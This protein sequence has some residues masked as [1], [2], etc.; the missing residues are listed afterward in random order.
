MCILPALLSIIIF[1]IGPKSLVNVLIAIFLMILAL[2]LFIPGLIF[3]IVGIK[4]EKKRLDESE[5]YKSEAGFQS[6][7]ESENHNSTK[8]NKIRKEKIEKKKKNKKNQS[9]QE[10]TM[11]DFD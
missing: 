10:F 6:F 2:I 5:A 1:L 7:A 8:D 3:L 9:Q 4:K 11:E